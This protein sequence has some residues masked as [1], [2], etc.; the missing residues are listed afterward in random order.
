MIRPRLR[1]RRSVPDDSSA[2]TDATAADID[3]AEAAEPVEPAEPA[4]RVEPVEPAEPRPSWRDRLLP[5]QPARSTATAA[6]EDDA[7]LKPST[8]RGNEAM[9]G[10]LVAAELILV[11]I[12]NLTVTHGAGASTHPQTA[13]SVVGLLASIALL[14][15]IRFTN[16]RFIVPLS[17]IGAAFFVTLPS[18]VPNTVR[19]AHILALIIPVIYA[20][21]LTQRQRRAA[22]AQAKERRSSSGRAGTTKAAPAPRRAE[23]RRRGRGGKKASAQTGPS[24]SRRYTPPKPKRPRPQPA[25][26]P[27]ASPRRKWWGRPDS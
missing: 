16:H 5:S 25:P 27:A 23:D 15:I 20:F 9:W 26:E 2:D 3:P 21:V 24:A 4:E 7:S 17:A 11:S 12:L 1:S 18:Q 19:T 13:L 14:P 8:M 6:P 10:Y 22:T